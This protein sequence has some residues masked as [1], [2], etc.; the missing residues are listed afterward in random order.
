MAIRFTPAERWRLTGFALSAA[1]AMLFAVKG[2]LIKLIYVYPI[3]STSLLAVRMMLSLP[4]F[5]MVGVIEWRR[6]PFDKRPDIR[7]IGLAAVVGIIGY[8]VSSWLDFEGLATLEAQTERL[9]LFTYP[10]LVLLFGRVL[11]KHQLRLH[12]LVGASMSYAGLIVMFGANPSR[13]TPMMLGGAA[14][15]LTAAATFALYQLFAREMILR[16][17][18]GLFSAIALSAAGV[19]LILQFLATHSISVLALPPHAWLLISYL[20]IFSTIIPTFM[21]SAGTARIGA[22]GTAIISTLSPLVTIVLAIVVLG[23]PFGLPEA[24]GTALVIGGVGLFSWIESRRPS[25]RSLAASPD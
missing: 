11:L 18:P 20:A 14:L 16:C 23:E 7:S 24:A 6:R 9:I 3:D 21:M 2:V 15:V 12:A 13:L 1:G 5:A 22:Q 17:G 10:F 19:T 4:V 25:D 8:H